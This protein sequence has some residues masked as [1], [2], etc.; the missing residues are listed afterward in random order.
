MPTPAVQLT[1]RP[2]ASWS[3][4][5]GAVGAEAGGRPAT[6]DGPAAR[7]MHAGEGPVSEDVPAGMKSEPVPSSITVTS[8]RPRLTPHH[9]PFQG[10]YTNIVASMDDIFEH[11]RSCVRERFPGGVALDPGRDAGPGARREGW[12][13][14][15]HR[16]RPPVHG[17]YG[18]IW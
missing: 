18:D 6:K 4:D 7:G 1:T 17:R 15:P 16:Q 14:W 11:N 3:Q 13:G 8:L 9:R 5:R 10:I 12:T 2:P